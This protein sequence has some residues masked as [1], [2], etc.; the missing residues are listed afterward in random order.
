[1]QFTADMAGIELKVSEVAESSAWGAAANGLLGLGVYASPDELAKLPR[2][3]KDF[4]PQMKP[5]EVKRSHDGWKQ[6]VKRVL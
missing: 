3:Q 1:M 5:A 2:K 4:R 6:A